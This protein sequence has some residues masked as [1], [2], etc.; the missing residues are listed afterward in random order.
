MSKARAVLA[1]A[2]RAEV[3][4]ADELAHDQQVDAVRARRPQVR[5]DVELAAQADQALLG[6]HVGAVELRV[7]PTGA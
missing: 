7:S 6:P 5:V 1:Q 4:A 2:A 3:E